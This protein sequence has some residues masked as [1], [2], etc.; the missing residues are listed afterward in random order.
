MSLD[1]ASLPL[2]EHLYE[3]EDEIDKKIY[4]HFTL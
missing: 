2:H 1:C 4:L 3:D